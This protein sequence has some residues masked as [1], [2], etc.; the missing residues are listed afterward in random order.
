MPVTS[1]QVPVGT[2]AT[3]IDTTDVMPFELQIANND[4]TDT[5]Y[6][7]GPSVTT[8]NGMAVQKLE[9]QVFRL[10]PGDRLYAVSSKTGHTISFVKTT[11]DR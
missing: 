9:H 1:G 2:V 4:N 5:V 10:A 11:R 8:S 7:G 3:L 6:L